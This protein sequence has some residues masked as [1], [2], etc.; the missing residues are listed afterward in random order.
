[1]LYSV[2]KT[3]VI[4]VYFFMELW[5]KVMFFFFDVFCWM[6]FEKHLGRKLMFGH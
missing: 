6:L 5:C 2:F 3:F 4:L 1:M